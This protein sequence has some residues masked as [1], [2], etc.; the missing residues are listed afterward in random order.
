VTEGSAGSRGRPGTPGSGG[1]TEAGAVILR[2]AADADLPA[3]S[4]IQR[5]A[6]DG[7]LAPLG[8]TLTWNTP[9][10][11]GLYA[12]LRATDA[13]RFVV[14]ERDGE[15]VGFAS[16]WVRGGLWF[17]AFLFVLPA[18]QGRALGRRLLEAVLP[19]PGERA[20]DG[21]RL[22]LGVATDSLQP[23]SNALYARYGMIPRLPVFMLRGALTRPEAFPPLPDGI[24]AASF[25]PSG[26]AGGEASAPLHADVTTIVDREVLGFVRAADHGWLR[27]DRAGILL[28]DAD[29]EPLGYGYRRDDGRL[30]PVATLD[31]SLLPAIVGMLARAAAAD[32][33]DVSLLAT[34]AAGDAFTACLE[35]GL[36]IADP[37]TIIGWDRPFAD[38][39]R[40]LPLGLALV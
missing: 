5:V 17:L 32:D 10:I 39:S 24:V 6:L 34:G 12:H 7:Y 26:W 8:Q 3:C 15:L 19:G 40:Y 9:T 37:P 33:A 23:I 22:G 36:R 30:G 28:A 13:S 38:F 21:E 35:A 20:P 11:V 4:E 31:A 1:P 27:R 29:G 25:A 14:A 16:A 2:R 18:E